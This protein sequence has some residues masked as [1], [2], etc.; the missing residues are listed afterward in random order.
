MSNIDDVSPS[1]EPPADSTRDTGEGNPAVDAVS[2]T[3]KRALLF[4]SLTVAGAVAAVVAVLALTFGAGVWAGSEFGDEY[5]RDGHGQSES[6]SDERDNAERD[7]DGDPRRDRDSDNEDDEQRPSVP[8]R[9]DR[10]SV[11]SPVAP[12]SAPPTSGR[13]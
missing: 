11:T 13:S 8:D 5:G 12:T 4:R 2:D 1:P 7:Y 6:H 3:R 10:P 9:G